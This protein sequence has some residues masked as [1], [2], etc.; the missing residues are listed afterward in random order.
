MCRSPRPRPHRPRCRLPGPRRSGRGRSAR[1]RP[2][3]RIA[4]STCG[5]PSPAGSWRARR[6]TWSS[7]SAGCRWRRT[8]PLRS[9]SPR[10][11]RSIRPRAAAWRSPDICGSCRADGWPPSSPAAASASSRCSAPVRPDRRTERACRD[12]TSTRRSACRP[13]FALASRRPYNRQHCSIRR[14]PQHRRRTSTMKFRRDIRAAVMMVSFLSQS[15]TK[16]T[17]EPRKHE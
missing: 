16:A 4:H 6:S 14:A 8:P 15:A 3:G 1:N 17:T 2:P 12:P 7:G 11:S 13:L 9:A 10:R 5:A